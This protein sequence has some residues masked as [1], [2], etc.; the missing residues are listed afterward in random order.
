M[1]VAAA[2]GGESH[3][4]STEGSA[5][6]G[7]IGREET[8]ADELECMPRALTI[9]QPGVRR[10]GKG[11]GQSPHYTQGLRCHDRACVDGCCSPFTH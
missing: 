8:L 10:Q 6:K 3:I 1:V 11:R 4:L 9:D 2:K 7:K 5:S